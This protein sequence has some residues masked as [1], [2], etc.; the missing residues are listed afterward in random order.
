M[1]LKGICGKNYLDN[2]GKGVLGQNCVK[3]VCIRSYSGPHFPPFGPSVSLRIQSGCG[4]ARTG[5]IPNA[6][7]FY[8]VQGKEIRENWKEAGKTDDCFSVNFSQLLHFPD[9]S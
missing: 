8:A 1:I 2:P 5:M 9:I 3:S 4:R 7:T 6:V